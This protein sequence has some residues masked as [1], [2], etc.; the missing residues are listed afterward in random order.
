MFE[1][2]NKFKQEIESFK[3]DVQ[4]L[5]ENKN[6]S[7]EVINDIEPMDKSV[8]NSLNQ[9]NTNP[10]GNEYDSAKSTAKKATFGCVGCLGIV[11]IIFAIVILILSSMCL[12]S[13]A[14]TENASQIHK[15]SLM[16]SGLRG[17]LEVFIGDDAYKDVQT[18]SDVE[19]ILD[20]KGFCIKEKEG[21][22]SSEGHE[23]CLYFGFTSEVRVAYDNKGRVATISSS[24]VIPGSQVIS[25][26]VEWLFA[27]L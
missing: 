22:L 26:L 15:P 17:G 20:S 11:G 3:N 5:R 18:K 27:G 13:C 14:K 2:L 16:E 10:F 23:T 7:A 21:I 12:K 25:I 1:E 24:N 8:N 4:K 6:S 19:K 9:Q